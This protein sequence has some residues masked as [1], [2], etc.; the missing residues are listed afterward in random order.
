MLNKKYIVELSKDERAY[1]SAFI[2]KGKRSA[3]AILKAC[4]L[5]KADQGA[6]GEGWID[7]KI[8]DALD[9]NPTMV[10]KVRAKLGI[11]KYPLRAIH[12]PLPS[13]FFPS[14]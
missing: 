2:S 5:L 3:Q 12:Y 6:F 1:L 13:P 8:C 11:S 14:I 4:I 9:T 10:V 7:T